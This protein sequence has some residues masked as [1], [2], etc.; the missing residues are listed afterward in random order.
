MQPEK[1]NPE[2]KIDDPEVCRA[3]LEAGVVAGD[4]V[5]IH[6]SLSSMGWVQ[7]GAASVFDGVL[8]AASPGGTVAMPTLWYNGTEERNFPEQFDVR[9]SPAWNGAL[10]EGMRKD[11][12]SFRSQ[13]FSH[14]V[15]AL[16]RR[17]EELTRDSGVTGLAPSPWSETA[18]AA[19]SP[20]QRL[21]EW[22]A[23]YAFI[24]VDFSVC[25]MKHYIESRL[26][27]RLL[28]LL[29]TE[30]ERLAKRKELTKDCNRKGF[31]PYLAGAPIEELLNEHSLLKKTKLGSATLRVVRTRPL[32]EVLGQ[33]LWQNPGK[34]FKEEFL[35]WRESILR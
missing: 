19:A 22:N 6:G 12:N 11:P 4:T 13:H 29:P 2:C 28:S 20:W 21:Y 16:G 25:T 33:D 34:W 30:E 32:V 26:V 14:A 27:S 1:G 17:A 35:A 31:W 23:L 10:A 18:F 15:S 3:F 24:G 8:S 5:L 9:N 7:R